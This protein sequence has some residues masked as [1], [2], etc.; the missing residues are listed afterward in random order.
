MAI[1]SGLCQ[2]PNRSGFEFG[3][4]GKFKKGI[5]TWAEPKEKK[6][7]GLSN[8]PSCNVLMVL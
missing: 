4:A 2:K 3:I 7:G 5:Y 8:P 1:L 6:E